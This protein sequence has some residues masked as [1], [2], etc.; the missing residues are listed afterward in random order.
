MAKMG[1]FSANV[2]FACQAAGGDLS[3]A[4][5]QPA[6]FA[7]S[8]LFVFAEKDAERPPTSG[9]EGQ[10]YIRASQKWLPLPRVHHGPDVP[11]G[12]ELAVIEHDAC[13]LLH[14]PLERSHHQTQAVRDHDSRS[15]R[16]VDG[17]GMDHNID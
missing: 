5:R 7:A 14:R 6:T 8:D 11:Q 4:Q 10:H 12:S 3:A 9:L 16:P 2:P 1:P 13:G 17:L 15:G